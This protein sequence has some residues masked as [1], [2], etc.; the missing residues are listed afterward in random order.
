MMATALVGTNGSV[1]YTFRVDTAKTIMR[2]LKN[3]LFLLLPSM[4]IGCSLLASNLSLQLMGVL[5][6][7]LTV[8]MVN[9]FKS[10]GCVMTGMTVETTK[11]N[12]TAVSSLKG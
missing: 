6:V 1:C 7:G 2:R 10:H 9:V 11:M 12:R 8:A 4:V 5:L 3:A